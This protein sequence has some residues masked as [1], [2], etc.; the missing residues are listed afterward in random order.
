VNPKST[1]SYVVY[2]GNHQFYLEDADARAAYA[3]M[4]YQVAA[5]DLWKPG[6]SANMLSVIPGKV[7]VGTGSYDNVRVTIDLFDQKPAEDLTD[8]DHVTE[9]TLELSSGQL[10]IYGCPDPDVVG[11]IQVPSAVYRLRIHYGNLE[12][13]ELG[14]AASNE[15]TEEEPGEEEV[16]PDHYRIV[17]W[18]EAFSP[19][20]ILKR[21]ANHPEA[22]QGS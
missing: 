11:T 6:D 1:H 8:W 2:A 17:L 14:G 21:W 22:S 20:R 5:Q 16:A 15:G 12:A 9:A 3:A 13:S 10:E 19:P 4:D 7:A 18:P